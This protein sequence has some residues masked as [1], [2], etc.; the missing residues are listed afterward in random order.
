MRTML[1]RWFGVVAG[2]TLLTVAVAQQ[3]AAAVGAPVPD[4]EFEGLIGHDGRTRLAELRG[5]PVLIANFRQHLVDGVHAAWVAR[6]LA[7]EFGD[8]G[9][10]VILVDRVAWPRELWAEKWSFWLRFFVTPV[11]L[12][13]TLGED[14]DLPIERAASRND[15]RSLVLIGVDGT[16]V[17]E[18]TAE[19]A[20][21]PKAAGDYRAALRK[22]VAAECRRRRLGW[23]EPETAR[24]ARAAAF[25]KADFAGA[26]RILDNVVK[27]SAP[28]APD[29]QVVRDELTQAFAWAVQ[30]LQRLV[31]EGRFVEADPVRRRLAEAARNHAAL[32]ATW[33]T[34]AD[35]VT[36]PEWDRG[37]RLDRELSQLT[38][39][40]LDGQLGKLD[41][42]DLVTVRRF[43][44]K[45]G[46]HPVA[47]RAGTL[48]VAMAAI[49]RATKGLTA[50]QLQERLDKAMK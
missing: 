13:P 38:K 15:E 31:A 3:T 20:S 10:I 41:L 1:R 49:V 25:G 21:A 18:G 22:A 50:A 4:L 12:A 40:Y 17:S 39:T 44:G 2:L 46:D 45:H 19:L 28:P 5:Q 36:G 33:A 26:M 8:E 16:L 47:R 9:L 14:R 48:G 37:L 42:D 23:G 24:S 11:W 29:L 30:R 34:V 43:A 27:S 7:R 6:D 32:A 35:S